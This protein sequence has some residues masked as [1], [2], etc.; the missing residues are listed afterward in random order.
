MMKLRHT[1]IPKLLLRLIWFFRRT[2]AHFRQIRTFL[3]I[4]RFCSDL[5]NSGIRQI[6]RNSMLAI[7][8]RF[9]SRAAPLCT[10]LDGNL[11]PTLT[12][13]LEP[14]PF[15]E[16]AETGSRHISIKSSG[17]TFFVIIKQIELQAKL[18]NYFLL[19]SNKSNINQSSKPFIKR[20]VFPAI[21]PH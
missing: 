21:L 18:L 1:F 6:V 11:C 15:S 10:N 14:L 19:G 2:A 20:C 8:T 5:G 9:N 4:F 13:H 17:W 16:L 3:Q 12:A 7:C